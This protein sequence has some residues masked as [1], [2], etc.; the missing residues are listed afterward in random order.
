[1][2]WLELILRNLLGEL[3]YKGILRNELLLLL[4]LLLLGLESLHWLLGLLLSVSIVERR[5]LVI[6]LTR[7][8]LDSN[9]YI[10]VALLLLLIESVAW[11]ENGDLLL[12]SAIAALI[13]SVVII[14]IIIVKSAGIRTSV[15]PDCVNDLCGD[16][17]L[18]AELIEIA[19]DFRIGRHDVLEASLEFGV[20]H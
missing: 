19:V 18:L 5:I 15:V 16:S 3:W 10:E 12:L 17:R 7:N 20:N 6:R 8:F 13:V 9:V 4:L 14:I 2:L 1:M 11:N